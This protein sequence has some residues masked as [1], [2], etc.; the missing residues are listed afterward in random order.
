MISARLR[1]G[2]RRSKCLVYRC[3]RYAH[4]SMAS[5][6]AFR[7]AARVSRLYLCRHCLMP[8]SFDFEGTHAAARIIGFEREF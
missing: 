5:F 8:A 1:L 6:A 7:Y 4:F 3:R 2:A